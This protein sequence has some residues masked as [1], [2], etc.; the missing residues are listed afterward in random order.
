MRKSLFNQNPPKYY[1]LKELTWQQWTNGLMKE[2][3]L[4]NDIQKSVVI[5][6]ADAALQRFLDKG[7]SVHERNA[8]YDYMTDGIGEVEL[9]NNLKMTKLQK[10]YLWPILPSITG[11][12]AGNVTD[13]ELVSICHKFYVEALKA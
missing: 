8:V 6:R 10:S 7:R 3:K 12:I 5:K 11:Y 1:S 4:T 13:K 2:A 9:M